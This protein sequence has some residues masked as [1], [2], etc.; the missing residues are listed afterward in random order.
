MSQNFHLD[1]DF[2]QNLGNT[3][4]RGQA[5]DGYIINETNYKLIRKR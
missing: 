5:T 3:A 4:E 2:F 1:S